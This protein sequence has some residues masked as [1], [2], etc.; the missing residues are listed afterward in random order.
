MLC[1]YFDCN[2]DKL[3]VMGDIGF[4]YERYFLN[5]EAKKLVSWEKISNK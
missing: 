4:A 2:I 3:S 1:Q 5:E